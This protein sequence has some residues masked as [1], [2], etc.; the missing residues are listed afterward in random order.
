MKETSNF[1]VEDKI[2]DFWM[3]YF[4]EATITETNIDSNIHFPVSRTSI[5]C[6]QFLIELF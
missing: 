3:E 4:V 6:I 1:K 5:S 2:F